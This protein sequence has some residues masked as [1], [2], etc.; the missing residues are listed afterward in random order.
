[1]K[2]T[3]TLMMIIFTGMIYAQNLVIFDGAGK[4]QGS[5]WADPKN[6]VTLSVTDSVKF[7]KKNTL[8]LKAKCKNWWGG[9]GWNWKNWSKNGDDISQYDFISFHIK[10]S[11]GTLNDVRIE[12]ADSTNK[13]SS[14]VKL[15]KNGY[16]LSLN[17]EFVKVAI[18]V[19]EFT[20]NFNNKSVTAINLAIVPV[21]ATGEATVNLAQLEFCK[22]PI[23]AK[24]VKAKVKTIKNKKSFINDKVSTDSQLIV[25]NGDTVKNG[26]GWADPKGSSI[27]ISKDVTY[28]GRDTLKLDGRW[29][30]WWSGGGWNWKNYAKNGDDISQFTYLTFMIKKGSGEISD[31]WIQLVDTN[32]KASNQIKLVDTGCTHDIN[33]EFTKVNIPLSL[34]K[35]KV[36]KKSVSAM[37]YGFVPKS[38]AGECTVYIADMEFNKNP[39]PKQ[40]D[41]KLPSGLSL[42]WDLNKAWKQTSD[43]RELIC[44]NGLWK[45]MPAMTNEERLKPPVDGKG[46]GWFKVPGIWPASSHTSQ[47]FLL[48]SFYNI[49]KIKNMDTAWYRRSIEVPASW[50]GKK[51]S[52]SFDMVQTQASVFLDGKHV[53]EVWFPGG[54][55]DISDKIVFNKKQTLAILITARPVDSES[56]VFMAPD[57]IIKK[58]ANVKLKG[59]TGDVY[60]LSQPK[61][62]IIKDVRIET[63]TRKGSI[64]FDINIAN[65]K[66]GK[67]SVDAVIM[68]KGKKVKEFSFDP[69]KLKFKNGRFSVSA[70]WKDA[71]LWDTDTPGNMYEAII[72]IKKAH[73]NNLL[74]Q[75]LPIRF[76]FREFWIDGK[77][78]YL[79]GSK[80]HLRALHL[81][82]ASEGADMA[83]QSSSLKALK[84]MTEYG[85]NFF[86]FGN[87]TFKHGEVGY[88]NGLLR[89]SD[90]NGTLC[91]FSLPHVSD[92]DK[93]LHQPAVA[94]KYRSLCNYLI[95]KVQN[96]PA[97]IL[98]AMNHNSM[99]YS[100]DQNP[101]K[102]DGRWKPDKSLI[103][104][105]NYFF[106]SRKQGEITEAIAQSIDPSR[107][108]YHHESGNFSQMHTVNIYLNWSP[109]QERSDWLEHWSKVG[110]KPVFFVEWGMPH[111]ASWSSY[112]GPLFIWTS[113]GLH[114]IWDSEFTA[115]FIGDAA[116]LMNQKKIDLLNREI[117]LWAEGKPFG[118]WEI[119]P[120]IK[121]LKRNYNDI[122]A[123]FMNDNLRSHR[124]WGIS[125]F[126][127]WD[128][129]NLWERI[130]ESPT[131]KNSERYKNLNK[132]GIIPDT[133]EPGKGFLEDPL[134]D[135]FR[136]TST[137][138]VIKKWNM[139]L[140]AFI[141]GYPAFSDK[142][143][144]YQAG[145]KVSK[146]L[147]IL[148]DTRR[149]RT[150]KYTWKLKDSNIK[151]SGQVI[152]KPGEKAFIPISFKMPAVTSPCT[153][154]AIF[155][156]GNGKIIKDQFKLDLLNV[157]KKMDSFSQKI[158][159]Y[160]PKGKST[161][162]FKDAKIPFTKIDSLDEIEDN[163]ILVIGREA[164]DKSQK[165]ILNL[166]L[167]KDYSRILFLEQNY[168]TL[169]K[170]LGFRATELGV[171]NVAV[172]SPH[173]PVV[174][175]LTNNKFKNWRGAS[176]MQKPYLDLP[177]FETSNP[178]WSWCGFENKRVWRCGNR[179]AVASAI[180]EKPAKGNWRPILDCGFDMQYSPLMEFSNDKST[181]IFCQMDISG[182]TKN[183]P[184]AISLLQNM[185]TYLA[186]TK[187]TKFRQ[188]F[189]DGD[190]RGKELLEKL[191]VKF[192]NMS[193]AKKLPE[194]SL[195]VLG[196][197]SKSKNIQPIVKTGTNV[198]A[199]GLNSKELNSIL[200]GKIQS[201]EKETISFVDNTLTQVPALSGI[202]NA[203]IHW[204]TFPKITALEPTKDGDNP[205]L[206]TIK[207][208]KGSVV[209]SQAMPWHFDYIAKPYL[210]TT[211][212]RNVFLTARLLANAGAELKS[213]LS[214][215]L[216]KPATLS[217]QNISTGWKV[218][219]EKKLSNA[220]KNCPKPGFDDSSWDVVSLPHS[221]PELG[222]T[223]YRLKFKV[224]KGFSNDV[225]IS[226]GR[227][228]DESMV[229]LNGKFLGEITKKNSPTNYWAR[230]RDYKLP[231][232]LVNSDSTNVIVVRVNNIY[233]SGGMTG[234]PMLTTKGPWLKS[235]YLQT[236][237]ADDDP[238]RY[239]RW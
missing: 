176:T 39:P 138:E 123:W 193:H 80:I 157:K 25:F 133:F 92:Y 12:L 179:N 2:K 158:V 234:K 233:L 145:E 135:S 217:K 5:G 192:Q 78:F 21:T 113:L 114:K 112:R 169:T 71:E 46:W 14:K 40:E 74:D 153:L 201:K 177:N 142:T 215:F 200:P 31:L 164:F 124:T 220:L 119:V 72:S 94:K 167:L 184:V 165:S 178:T 108:I 137:G 131:I 125:A 7:G 208:G 127:P 10:K 141:G 55:L 110:T 77:D 239:Y 30:K 65:V 26:G 67:V 147:T 221:Y 63:S 130:K 19:K 107:P 222:Y 228:D 101:M 174:S 62:N 90:E 232:E 120:Y 1:M 32:N 171:R 82:N 85:F 118:Y 36:N 140:L 196:P 173:H 159:L 183:E 6:S 48:P 237:V 95:R 56:N 54:E 190:N 116:Y 209:L 102:I 214:K 11:A 52:L 96:H 89:A 134:N 79:N 211:Y 185:L 154:S 42:N 66:E 43:T 98:Y 24:P 207:Y 4:Q 231:K 205:A 206:R 188:V 117:Q 155:D 213:P 202:S 8:Q 18:P 60:L 156:F 13:A 15:I 83:S 29:T 105:D 47:K 115:P 226:L 37:N 197:S 203:E 51:I 103:G 22:G 122:Q 146:Q 129:V 151:K 17:D 204:R 76:G 69:V 136:P 148:N 172:R 41:L 68:K 216:S 191:G 150:C 75:T 168:E 139:P 28:Q 81:K 91:A 227:C 199:L 187:A 16:C 182:R 106:K 61:Q 97:V 161:Q 100:G 49:K 88:M 70:N 59:L 229:W 236:P 144:I 111:V 87:Y 84:K 163:V 198:L 121:R 195:L 132:P 93:K 186:K 53:G 223:W 44:L 20:G 166:N 9:G 99:G 218:K 152:I 181:I 170:R 57:R 23:P 225:T 34:I 175:G 126:L 33:A 128:Q 104:S 194:N 3:L 210:R 230:T 162:L 212:R 189:Y 27:G 149:P 160:D 224:A 45:F 219:S 180:I 38:I 109:R 143:H 238:Y 73:S 86:I 235:Y 64:K 50:K 58:R 35:G